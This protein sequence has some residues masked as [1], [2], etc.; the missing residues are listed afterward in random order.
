[1][2]YINIVFNIDRNYI[3]HCAATLNSIIK[4]YTGNQIIRFYVVQNDLSDIDKFNLKRLVTNTTHELFFLSINNSLL[5]DMP[6]GD[7]TISSNI[8]ISTYFRLFLTDLLP[9]DINKVLYLDSDIIVNSNI[10]ELYLINIDNYAIAG[11]PD[12]ETNQKCNKERLSIPSKYFYINAGVLLMN[13]KYL[14]D[15][16]F[17]KKISSFVN[18]NYDKILYHDQDILNALL[19]NKIFYIPYKW[20]MMDCYLYK[21][22]ICNSQYYPEVISSQNNPGIIHFAGYY[23]P[24]NI[25]CKNPYR[26]L[27]KTALYGTCWHKYK[28]RF[29]SNSLVA[30]IKYYTKLAIKGNIYFK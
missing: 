3:Q 4:T 9:N 14:R 29:K 28:K 18:D 21:K 30:I 5:N 25:E 22:P 26:H 11:V 16:K 1:M 20:N 13:I 24:W 19:Y 7:N 15:I 8:T 23:K 17:T 27:Y 2:E 10:E 12:K 6:I